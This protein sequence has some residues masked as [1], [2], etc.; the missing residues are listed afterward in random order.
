M[1]ILDHKP[2][3]L[4]KDTHVGFALW[5]GRPTIKVECLSCNVMIHEETTGTDI[6]W[7][8]HTEGGSLYERPRNPATET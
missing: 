2:L 1:G 8:Q 3:H 5:N 4:R 7:G 6:R